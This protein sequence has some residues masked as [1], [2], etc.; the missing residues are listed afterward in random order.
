MADFVG[1]NTFL[2]CI[3]GKMRDGFIYL[4]QNLFGMPNAL[5]CGYLK[6]ILVG[7]VVALPIDSQLMCIR[8]LTLTRNG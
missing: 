1:R 3:S 2:A 6:E 5:G 4:L 8:P 7:N